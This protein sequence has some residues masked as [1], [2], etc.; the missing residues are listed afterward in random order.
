MPFS[1]SDGSS[2]RRNALNGNKLHEST[3][4]Y[5]RFFEGYSEYAVTDGK[6]HVVKQRVYTGDYVVRA[7][8]SGQS[9]ARK[10]FY[11]AL[12]PAGLGV[13][14]FAAYASFAHALPRYAELPGAVCLITL[15]FYLKAVIHY[16]LAGSS[17]TLYMYRKSSAPLIRCAL[18]LGAGFGAASILALICAW[19]EIAAGQAASSALTLLQTALLELGAAALFVLAAVKERNTGYSRQ[20]STETV[21]ETV[22]ADEVYTVKNRRDGALDI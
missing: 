12:F 9:A 21:P 4:A 6:N 17:M 11:A 8:T 5:E 2:V 20:S 1:R 22:P 18:I 13:L 16:V 14:V 19:T 15:M 7:L 10:V 3:T